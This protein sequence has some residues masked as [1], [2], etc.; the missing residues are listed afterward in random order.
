MPLT[1]TTS[2]IMSILTGSLNT[3]KQDGVLYDVPP[4]QEDLQWYVFLCRCVNF[5]QFF[6]RHYRNE[7]LED[8]CL[9]IED[10]GWV[11]DPVGTILSTKLP[12]GYH[13]TSIE[14]S[15]R[16]YVWNVGEGFPGQV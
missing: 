1:C 3:L 8:D 16:W 10:R 4:I 5:L 13:H 14:L 11:Q 15:V 7:Y 12:T 9:N 6:I 2:M